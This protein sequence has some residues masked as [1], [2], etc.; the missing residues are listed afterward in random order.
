MFDELVDKSAGEDGCWPWMGGTQEKGYGVYHTLAQAIPGSPTHAHRIAYEFEYGSIPA[1]MEVDHRCFVTACVNPH[2]LRLVTS[3][4]N[5]ENRQGAHGASGIR[6][7]DLYRNGKW[8]A[9]LR[10]HGRDVYLGYFETA[11]L[12]AEAVRDKRLELFTHSDMDRKA[13]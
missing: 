9:R 1:G 12:A 13:C 4:Q 2:H 5:K 3:K 10:H 6:G 8:R 11:E 7:V